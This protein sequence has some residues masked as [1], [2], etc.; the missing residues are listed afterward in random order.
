MRSKKRPRFIVVCT[1]QVIQRRVTLLQMGLH[2][3]MDTG[4]RRSSVGGM[5]G[6][7]GNNLMCV[8]V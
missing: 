8:F 2:G 7:N 5:V 4:R 1:E 6:Y 3:Y